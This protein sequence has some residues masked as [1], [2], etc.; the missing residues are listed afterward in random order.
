MRIAIIITTF[1]R[2]ELLRIILSQLLLQI[3]ENDRIIVI[4]DGSSDGTNEMLNKE[5][6]TISIVT[7]TGKWWYTR[8]VNEGF[9]FAS[10]FQPDYFLTFNDDVEIYYNYIEKIKEAAAIA[11]KNCIINSVAINKD[12]PPK[13]T[14]S[15]VKKFIRWNGR[16]VRYMHPFTE[17]NLKNLTG[18][19]STEIVSGRGLLI[20]SNIVTE[21]NFFDERFPQYGS[22]DDFG[23][24]ALKKGYKM[25]ICYDSRI[26]E[27]TKTTSAVIAYNKSTIPSFL[28]SF[29]DKYSINSIRKTILYS[30]KHGY[31][32]MLPVSI[33]IFFLG[34]FYAHFFKYKK[35]W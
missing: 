29:F 6:P 24:R 35:S 9:K 22:D 11:G 10:R 25:F 23:L 17:V 31:K 18:I 16:Y 2:K 26:I 12:C 30:W 13:I 5:F 21:L 32:I 15:G 4:D 20:P 33:L 27:N 19:Y 1:N 14:F 3:G 7:G 34:T 8:S 28:K